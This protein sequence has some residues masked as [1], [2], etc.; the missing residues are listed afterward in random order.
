MTNQQEVQPTALST[1]PHQLLEPVRIGQLNISPCLVLA[2]MSGVTC[3]GFR[4]LIKTLNPGSVGLVVSEFISVEGLTRG[5]KQSVQMM[6]FRESERPFSIQIFGSEVSRLADGARIAADAGA[7]IVDI[8]SGCPVPKVVRRGGGC[9]LM[10]Q[11]DHL[12]SILKAVRKA[13]SIP[14]TLKIRA[15]WDSTSRNAV[16]IARMAEDIGVDMVAVHGRTR[17][18]MY[19][20]AADWSIVSDVARSVRIPVIGS[21]DVVDTASLKM[22]LQSGVK[23]VMIGRG[24][25][26]NPWIFSEL[27]GDFESSAGEVGVRTPAEVLNM[28]RQ[29]ALILRETLPDKA[30]I[31]R[32]KQLGSQSTRLIRGS[33]Q[34]RKSLCRSSSVEAFLEQLQVAEDYYANPSLRRLEIEEDMNRG[35]DLGGFGASGADSDLARTYGI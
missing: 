34:L 14:L 10:R 5:N 4:H 29:Y 27:C 18:E 12:A 16:E 11:P 7:D 22:A 28:L 35:H 3:A 20:G 15:G 1:A 24:A 8:N 2:P 32:L 26:A 13:V 17:Q 25:I 6:S 33:S 31:G 19:R 23:G 21:G 9:E 30:V